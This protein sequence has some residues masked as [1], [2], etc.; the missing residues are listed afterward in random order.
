MRKVRGERHHRPDGAMVAGLQIVADHAG[1]G[2]ATQPELE[3]VVEAE[4]TGGRPLVL[5]G[6]AVPVRHEFA[7]DALAVH[8]ARDE[9]ARVGRGVAQYGAD[10]VALAPRPDL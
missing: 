9:H 2:V 6:P 8:V 1:A 5:G 3:D 10:L 4:G 7:A